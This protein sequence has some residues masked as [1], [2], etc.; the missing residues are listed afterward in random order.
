MNKLI[1]EKLKMPVVFLLT[2][3]LINNIVDELNYG[4]ECKT[5]ATTNICETVCDED[6]VCKYECFKVIICEEYQPKKSAR[7]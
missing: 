5:H 1:S 3:L 2:G 4:L 7:K 6:F